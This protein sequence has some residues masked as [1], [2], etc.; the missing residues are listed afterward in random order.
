M[1]FAIIT[2]GGKQYQAA[3][4]ATLKLEKLT[5]KEGAAVTFHDVLLYSDGKKI[6]VGKPFLKGVSVKAKIVSHGRADKVNV[7]KF[8]SKVRYRRKRGHRQHFTAVKIEKI[9]LGK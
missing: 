1:K 6:E 5:G 2:T 3:E 8:K 9:I 7:V 4:G